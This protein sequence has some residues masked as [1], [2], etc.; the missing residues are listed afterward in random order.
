MSALLAYPNKSK[1][2]LAALLCFHG[3]LVE[4]LQYFSGYRYGDWQDALADGLGVAL[5]VIL[6]RF[7]FMEELICRSVHEAKGEISVAGQDDA[8]AANSI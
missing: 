1:W 2:K 5:F 8:N 6:T 4:V 3:C 7:K